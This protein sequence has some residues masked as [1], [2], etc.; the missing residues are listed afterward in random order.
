MSHATAL[1]IAACFCLTFTAQAAE[2]PAP[3]AA[4]PGTQSTFHSFDQYDFTVDKLK[5]KI[6]TPRTIAQGTPW[7]WRARFFGH[8]PQT[9][10][11]LLERGFHVA[12]VDVSGLY[13]APKAVARWNSFYA[14]LTKKHGFAKKPALEAMSRGGLIAFNWA[15]KNPRKVACIYADAP[16]CDFKSWPGINS[17]ILKAYGLTERQAQSYRGNPVDNL[18]PLAKAGVPLLHVVGDADDVVPVAENTA[19]IEKRYK[20]LRGTITVIHKEGVGH[21]PHSLKDPEPIVSFI[22]KH[23]LG[24]TDQA[25]DTTDTNP[26]H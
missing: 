15:A 22:L 4:W 14:Y 9:D 26:A 11:A 17:K 1:L 7:V 24:D 20:K 19:V 18:R 3:D 21:H 2:P 5:C 16:V 25:Q 12:Y 8:Q 10:I 23:T 13:G 6:V